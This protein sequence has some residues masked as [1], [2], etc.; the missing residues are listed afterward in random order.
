MKYSIFSPLLFLLLLGELILP[1]ITLAGE[2]M[3][4]EADVIEGEKK[5][6]DL[7]LQM[8][9]ENA[10]LS[11]VIYDRKNFNDFS[12][13]DRNLRPKLTLPAGRKTTPAKG[14]GP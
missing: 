2:V 5:A 12:K 10:E 6:P 14:N 13:F 7:F 1:R 8:D 4:F 3:D 9:S 11:A